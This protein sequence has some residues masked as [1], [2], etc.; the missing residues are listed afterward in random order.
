M[1]ISAK[2]YS[3]P[4]NRENVIQEGVEDGLAEKDEEGTH[5][6]LR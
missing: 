3:D 5:T 4:T 6:I 1:T 2:K